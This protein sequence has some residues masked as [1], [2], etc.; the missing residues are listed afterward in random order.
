[1]LDNQALVSG[2][3]FNRDKVFQVIAEGCPE[4][5]SLFCFRYRDLRVLFANQDL[6]FEE[7]NEELL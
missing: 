7:T 4:H 6:Q 3:S 1:M 5:L 2:T